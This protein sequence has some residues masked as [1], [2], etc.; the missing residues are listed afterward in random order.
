MSTLSVRIPN[1]LHRQLR[2]LAEREG[3][4]INQL[5]NSAVAEKLA[6]L[7]TA[8]YL[9]ERAKQGSRKK[10]LAALRTIPDVEPEDFDRL[11]DKQSQRRKPDKTSSKS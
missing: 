3:T 11:P 2:E 6:S 10:F 8:G 4:S 9:E 1:S 7:M 5:I